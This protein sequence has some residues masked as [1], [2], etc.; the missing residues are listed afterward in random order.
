MSPF[1]ASKFLENL[2]WLKP[3]LLLTLVSFVLLGL[4]VTLPAAARRSAGW[5]ALI[6]IVVAAV[7]VASYTPAVGFAVPKLDPGSPAGGFLDAEGRASFVLDGF[8]VV[9]KLI[10]LLGAALCVL[11]AMR[12]LDIEG[13]QAGEFYAIVVFAV[14]GMMF[15]ASGND[16]ATIYIGL[17]TMALSSYVLVGFTRGSRTSNEAAFKYFLLGA[18]ASAILLYG[19]SLVFRTCT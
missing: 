10:F 15:L 2:L 3:E 1:D 12:F 14:L 17:E 16:F 9:L 4:S 11:M 7:L 5:V 13:A 8:A 18:F 6:G 19:V